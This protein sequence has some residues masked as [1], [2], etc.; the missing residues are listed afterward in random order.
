[1]DE[2]N[3]E[4]PVEEQSP[5]PVLETEEEVPSMDASDDEK[6]AFFEK[7]KERH[8]AYLEEQEE[9][10]NLPATSEPVEEKRSLFKGL[11]KR[12]AVTEVDSSDADEVV[13]QVEKKQVQPIPGR[14]I[15]KAIP[16]LLLSLALMALSVYFVSP[17]SKL[18]LISVEGNQRLSA[19]EVEALSLISPQDYAAT[20]ALNTSGY[21]D[22][23]R[24]SSPDIAEAKIAFQF[25]NQFTIQVKEYSIIGYVADGAQ[26]HRVLSNGEMASESLTAEQLPETHLLIKLNNQDAIKELAKQLGKVDEKITSKIQEVTLTPTKATSDL[27]TL[28]M[29]DGNMILVPLSEVETKLPYYSKIAL[30]TVVPSVIDMEVGIFRYAIT[31]Y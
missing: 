10:S 29:S 31:G 30:E 21:A 23:I 12:S 22:N 9:E 26:Y 7:W 13:E 25:P 8:Q 19:Q 3:Q 11:R 17:Y 5:A 6:S 24:K 2:K 18:K 14:A 4:I 27:L 28:T 20:I 1:M 15:A 16:V